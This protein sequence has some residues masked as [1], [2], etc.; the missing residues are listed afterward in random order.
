MTTLEHTIL[1]CLIAHCNE[2]N[3]SCGEVSK[4]SFVVLWR[5]TA[6]NTYTY[7]PD[8]NY[9]SC[10]SQNVHSQ[11]VFSISTLGD[12]IGSQCMVQHG[13]IIARVDVFHTIKST[14][15]SKSCHRQFLCKPHRF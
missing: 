13:D 3:L 7:P 11:N 8:G 15:R 5:S 2:P 1:F 10:H 9:Y 14:Q 6:S 12:T 4:T